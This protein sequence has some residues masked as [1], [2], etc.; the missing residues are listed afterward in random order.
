MKKNYLVDDFLNERER[1]KKNMAN[2]QKYTKTQIGNLLK[3]CD[4]SDPDRKY[5]NQE[6]NKSKT[7]LNYNLAPTHEGKTDFEFCVERCQNLKVLKRKDVN[8]MASWLITLPKD[9]KGDSKDFFKASYN[10]LESKYGKENVV[11]AYVHM[12]E[13][14]PH[15]HFSFVPVYHDLEKGVDKVNAKK[16]LNK[17][18]L[19]NFHSE[20]QNYLDNHLEQH[21]I[22]VNDE[23]MKMKKL[24]NKSVEDLKKEVKNNIINYEK[25]QIW[26]KKAFQILYNIF[27]NGKTEEEE[28]QFYK[29]LDKEIN[30]QIYEEHKN[31]SEDEEEEY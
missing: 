19:E 9:F 1:S 5:A 8:Y 25:D 6:I 4:R 26:F 24:K 7:H 17:E 30:K 31:L 28:N 23:T 2:V 16:L 20:L 15:M 21:C 18:H 22:V 3:H 27:T 29:D 13:T 11:G 10:F 12:D 14:T